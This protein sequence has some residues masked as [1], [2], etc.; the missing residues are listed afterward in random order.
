LRR[1]HELELL[2]RVQK[3]SERAEDFLHG[4][5]GDVLRK[6]PNDDKL[7]NAYNT[8][9]EANRFSQTLNNPAL[10][11]LVLTD[12]NNRLADS[13]DTGRDIPKIAGRDY[14]Q[15]RNRLER[16]GPASKRDDGPER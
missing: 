11:K 7:R 6:Y 4:R 13:L 16:E 14:E 15:L 12:V 3:R 8:L 1:A 5:A 9:A 2:G 10:Q